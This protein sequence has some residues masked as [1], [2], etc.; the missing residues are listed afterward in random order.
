MI[1]KDMNANVMAYQ[2]MK[3]KRHYP[4]YFKYANELRSRFPNFCSLTTGKESYWESNEKLQ[5]HLEKME[6]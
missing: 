4:E 3:W 1:A 2:M 6:P 5:N